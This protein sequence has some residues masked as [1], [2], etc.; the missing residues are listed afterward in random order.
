[1]EENNYSENLQNQENLNKEE[2]KTLVFNLSIE[3]LLLETA[4]WGKFL[5]IMG[6]VFTGLIVLVGLALSVFGTSMLSN[7][8]LGAIGGAALGFIYMLMGLVYYFPSKYLYDFA[9]YIKQAVLIKDQ[10]SLDYAF[11]RL[12]S[13]YKFWGILVIILL[14]FYAIAFLFGIASAI[15]MSMG[16]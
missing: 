5:A 16:S 11:S 7:S 1:M 14:V 8:P 12:K 10:E 4:K 9:V 6:F 13:V 2:P 15:F 3:D